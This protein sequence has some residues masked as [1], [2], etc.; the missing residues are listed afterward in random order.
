[1]ERL[2]PL[3][4]YL[5][6]HLSPD[7]PAAFTTA[8][9]DKKNNAGGVAFLLAPG[10]YAWENVAWAAGKLFGGR[11]GSEQQPIYIGPEDLAAPKPFIHAAGELTSSW[12]TVVQGLKVQGRMKITGVPASHG[13]IP[14]CSLYDC[15]M[16]ALSIQSGKEPDG[17]HRPV[18]DAKI[19][20]CRIQGSGAQGI[21]GDH[22]ERVLIDECEI[23]D[24][25]RSDT[26]DQGVYL[27]GD[28]DTTI[29][30]SVIARSS[31]AAFKLDGTIG[32]LIEECL[33]VDNRY[34]Y[35]A[36]PN[37]GTKFTENLTITR[38][39]HVRTGNSIMGK[40]QRNV[41]IEG[42]VWLDSEGSAA[43]FFMDFSSQ[44]T[45]ASGI[46]VRGNILRGW[47][48]HFIRVKDSAPLVDL[49]VEGNVIDEP[50]EWWGTDAHTNPVSLTGTWSQ[51]KAEILSC[52]RNLWPRWL[53]ADKR[54][55][56]EVA[57]EAAGRATFAGAASVGAEPVI[58]DLDRVIAACAVLST[59]PAEPVPEGYVLPWLDG[60]EQE[61]PEE[62]PPDEPPEEEPPEEEPP[63]EGEDW[64]EVTLPDGTRILVPPESVR[65]VTVI[66]R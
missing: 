57:G 22:S 31:S 39:V 45:P 66:P 19:V 37:A 38:N 5:I 2:F 41:L 40:G 17:S 3:D 15:E 63:V 18:R 54:L 44:T 53:P 35:T 25:G 20:R 24:C 49:T 47:R 6:V 27:S 11:R 8:V 64:Y 34:G 7:D 61:P 12:W 33:L 60:E 36:C 13:P 43:L 65:R 42:N 14:S 29:R 56:A 55:D 51:E 50:A 9:T 48:G 52:E 16:S 28:V 59:A 10:D 21:F 26:K 62:E 30:R 23:L 1:M 32:T 4:G 46:M 58:G